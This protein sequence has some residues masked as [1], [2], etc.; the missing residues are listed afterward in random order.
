MFLLLLLLFGECPQSSSQSK[1]QGGRRAGSLLHS[2]GNVVCH[3]AGMGLGK[4]N[5]GGGLGVGGH[6]GHNR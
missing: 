5:N 2:M 1:N 6:M 4:E 3:K